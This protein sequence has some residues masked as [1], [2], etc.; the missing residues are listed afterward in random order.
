MFKEAFFANW[1]LGDSYSAKK[2]DGKSYQA[3]KIMGW[4]CQKPDCSGLDERLVML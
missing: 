1:F 3:C 2:N 4:N